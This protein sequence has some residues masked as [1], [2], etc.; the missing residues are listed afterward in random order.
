MPILVVILVLVAVIIGAGAV[1]LS[2]SVMR[3]WYLHEIGR[4]EIAEDPGEAIV[5]YPLA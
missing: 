1:V 4:V 2:P 3:R 5:T